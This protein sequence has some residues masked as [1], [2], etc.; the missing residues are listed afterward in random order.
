MS[1]VPEGPRSDDDNLFSDDE[2]SKKNDFFDPNYEERLGLP[3][4]EQGSYD[5]EKEP[6][7]IMVMEEELSL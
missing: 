7:N 6:E 4:E 1:N 3:M 5:A 2:F